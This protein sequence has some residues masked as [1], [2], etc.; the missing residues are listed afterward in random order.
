M[1]SPI[2]AGPDQGRSIWT[3]VITP[4]TWSASKSADGSYALAG[5]VPTNELKNT[6]AALQTTV[7]LDSE[8]LANLLAREIQ[9][10]KKQRIANMSG[11]FRLR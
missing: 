1:I 3:S 8:F 6:I 2:P 11:F 4:F 10:M 9:T 5:Y 7:D